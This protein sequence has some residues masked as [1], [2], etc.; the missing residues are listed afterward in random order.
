MLDTLTTKTRILCNYLRSE[1]C[2]SEERAE[3]LAP[4]SNGWYADSTPNTWLL[5][6]QNT[7]DDE[8]T[9][10]NKELN[11][12][13]KSLNRQKEIGICLGKESDYH[14]EIIDEINELVSSEHQST[15]ISLAKT[16]DVKVVALW[17]SIVFLFVILLI[18]SFIPV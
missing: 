5:D 7:D 2:V 8:E 13:A 17:I 15:R 3:L 14:H 12:L 18:V 11:L 1:D 10:E 6:K 16:N 4:S 9:L